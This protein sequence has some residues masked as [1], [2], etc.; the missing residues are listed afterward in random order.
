M[1][2]L[3][4]EGTSLLSWSCNPWNTGAGLIANSG[5]D[6][7]MLKEGEGEWHNMM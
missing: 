4:G 6:I 1:Q 2:T 5:R 7:S 3:G